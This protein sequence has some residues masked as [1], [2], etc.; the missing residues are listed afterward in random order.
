MNNPA[1]VARLRHEEVAMCA[2]PPNIITPLSD[3][4][5]RNVTFMMQ[6]EAR[7]GV[8]KGGLL[9][10][11]MGLGKSLSILALI[12]NSSSL[13]RTL[14]VVPKN[15]LYNWENEIR[16][17]VRPGL[18]TYAFYYG[19]DR[20]DKLF[21]NYNVIL[22]TYSTVRKDY[23]AEKGQFDPT[24]IFHTQVFTRIVL[25]EA[26]ALRTKNAQQSRAC[27]ALMGERR[28]GLTGTPIINRVEDLYPFFSFLR[29]YPLAD[30]EYFQQKIVN[31]ITFRPRE[32]FDR[33][34][35]SLLECA[36]RH[37]KSEVLT[38]L[39]RNNHRL[40]L[41]MSPSEMEYYKYL[42]L[43]FACRT[44]HL[45]EMYRRS[46]ASHKSVAQRI[47]FCTVT[48]L[49][50]LRQAA[51]SRE[52][53]GLEVDELRDYDITKQGCCVCLSSAKLAWQLDPC[54]HYVCSYCESL[55]GTEYT[56]CPLCQTYCNATPIP[57][58]S[59]VV[60]T[61]KFAVSSTQS[62]KTA[63]VLRI[64]QWSA[65]RKVVVFSF[66]LRYLDILEHWLTRSGIKCLRIEGKVTAP[67]RLQL[68]E[69][70][71]KDPAIRVMLCSLT[72]ASEGLNLQCSSMAIIC[73]PFWNEARADQASGR[74]ER[75]GQESTTVDIY[76]LVSGGTVEE[77]VQEMCEKKE[78]VA[79]ATLTGTNYKTSTMNWAN[80]IHLLMRKVLY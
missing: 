63:Q 29:F 40:V 46:H 3:V 8:D 49:T 13:G 25:D 45:L 50:K 59:V 78:Q 47:Q 71:F 44:T 5:R 34:C 51:C 80:Q 66:W 7:T 27:R 68:Q 53:V 56:K 64:I 75:M 24:C 11:E 72:S 14:I 39:V 73:E 22:T 70:F 9:L 16:K 19:P 43:N 31:E 54:K 32:I 77:Q 36:I 38:T 52:L 37:T 60:E 48:I 33:I 6:R 55:I 42:R 17:H 35:D 74:V 76:Y 41:P 30:W 62:T 57:Q 61:D 26:H 69:Q 65:P 10:D 18:L 67:R 4:Q 23:S 28:W 79:L 1:F 58:T 15:V 2:Q 20:H 21:S 12:V